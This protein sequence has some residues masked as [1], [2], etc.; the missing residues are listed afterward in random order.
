MSVTSPSYKPLP[1]CCG[2][3]TIECGL[4]EDSTEA[5][6]CWGA[7]SAGTVETTD[8][9]SIPVHHCSGHRDIVDFG[10]YIPEFQP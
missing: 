5:E 7:V 4:L 10:R 3:S 8:G 2:R 1:E 9:D 6:P